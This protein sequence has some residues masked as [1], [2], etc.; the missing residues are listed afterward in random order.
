[1]VE[2]QFQLHGRSK[3]RRVVLVRRRI[4]GAI[5]C[6]RRGD[7]QQLRLE[8]PGPSVHEGERL[9]EDAVL[10]T[11]V[12]YPLDALGQLYRDAPMRRTPSTS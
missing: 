6:E 4:R 12:G 2:A 9:W 8:L 5:A 11:D 3:A 1:M 10:V 7:G